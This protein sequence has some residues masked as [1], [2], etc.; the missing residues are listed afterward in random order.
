MTNLNDTITNQMMEEYFS[1]FGEIEKSYA[2]YHPISNKHKGFGFVIFKK[3]EDVQKVLSK[4]YHNINGVEVM[5]NKNKLKEE[6]YQPQATNSSCNNSVPQFEANNEPQTQQYDY[7]NQYQYVPVSNYGPQYQQAYHGYEQ[8]YYYEQEQ[9]NQY[10]NSQ[11]DQHYYGQQYPYDYDYEKN[12]Y[13]QQYNNGQ[14]YEEQ[15]RGGYYYGQQEV[16][17][18]YYNNYYAENGTN[19]NYSHYYYGPDNRYF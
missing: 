3:Q 15:Y 7:T 9:P 2:A 17:N 11:T 8:G 6:C 1:K 4:K 19:D 5:A 12:G 18:C 10:Y 13:Y 16:N 14:Y